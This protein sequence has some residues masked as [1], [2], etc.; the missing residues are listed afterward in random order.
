IVIPANG[1]YAAYLLQIPGLEAVP[2]PFQGVVTLRVVAGAGVTASSFRLLRNERLD[3]LVT[4]T[5]LLNE[6][7]G[8]PGRVIFPYVTDSTGYTTQFILI[9]PPGV[10][11]TSGIV[12]YWA[13]DG[14]PLQIDS[15]KLG[16]IQIVPFAG[17]ATPHA[18][19]ILLHRDSG[20]MTTMVGVEG[21]LP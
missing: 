17:F 10:Q 21:Q 5:G 9:N 20:V 13:A 14:T 15:L 6:N 2:V 4:T 11:N 16:S 18:H 8:M 19:V 12:H 1:Q 7:A 3:L